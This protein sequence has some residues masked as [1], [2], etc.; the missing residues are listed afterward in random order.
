MLSSVRHRIDKAARYLLAQAERGFPET[1]HTMVFPHWAGFTGIEERQSSDV[2]ARAVVGSV[3]LDIAALLSCDAPLAN[4]VRVAA[5]LE[6]EYVARAKVRDRAGG[7]SYFAGLPELPPDVDSLSAAMLLFARVAPEFATLCE[8]P[9]ALALGGIHP[10]G[11]VDTWI[12]GPEEDAFAATC[13]LAALQAARRGVVSHWGRGVDVDVCANFVRALVTQDPVRFAASAEH[14]V[15]FII[16]AQRASGDWQATWYFGGTYGTALCLD[17]LRGTMVGKSPK[18]LAAVARALGFLVTA[19]HRDG[20]WGESRSLPLDTAMAL[21]GLGCGTLAER[22]ALRD[23]A[24]AFLLDYQLDDGSWGPSPWIK[25]PVGRAGGSRCRVATHGSSTV[26]TAFCLRALLLAVASK[27]TRDVIEIADGCRR[28]DGA[29]S[30][31]IT[32][33]EM[34]LHGPRLAAQPSA[35]SGRPVPSSIADPHK[36]GNVS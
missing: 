6:A 4:G 27:N 16:S 35:L 9:I 8:T 34:F 22:P 13:P 12:F 29:R 21:W 3:L 20:G 15:R 26:A 23:R 11:S 33:D 10:D 24:V 14:G 32:G 19:Q 1:M 5:R 7:W 36:E 25:M 18:G 30:L 17:A 31:T 28:T 2:F